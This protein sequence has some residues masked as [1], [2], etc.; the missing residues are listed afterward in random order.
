MSAFASTSRSATHS[1]G[2]GNKPKLRTDAATLR[3]Y[4]CF[5]PNGDVL[6]FCN[7]NP[8]IKAIRRVTR[9]ETSPNLGR[10]FWSC[11]N[12]IEGDGCGLFLWC[13][14]A[15]SKGRDF[16][17]PPPPGKPA[18]GAP[19]NP[20]TP[21]SSPQKR[22]R[23][24]SPSVFSPAGSAV[25]STPSKP[26]V[27]ES[28]DD[29]DFDSFD[30][31]LDDEIEDADFPSSSTLSASPGKKP[32]FDSFSSSGAS[33]PTP[34][35]PST[36]QLSQG[37]HWQAA[38]GAGAGGGTTRARTGGF[39]AIRLDPDSPFHALQ[40]SLFG[41]SG[42]EGASGSSPAPPSPSK[43]GPSAQSEELSALDSLFA[44]LKGL[45]DL[46]DAAKKEREKDARLQTAAKRKEE[47][48]R[49]AVERAK[50][51]TEA[52]RRENE[53]LKERIRMLEEENNELRTR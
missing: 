25:P 32:R 44:G 39:D 48:L 30:A 45:S 3:K 11:G 1:K 47:T 15:A 23:A 14:E 5:L 22:P 19:V 41:G 16:T 24:C 13:D 20:P 9:K 26:L 38:G 34:A 31:T 6:C 2:G 27:T 53:G 29:V 10:E 37:P 12:W 35:T 51:E 18:L 42:G 49:K 8:R 17:T 50:E 40:K 33:R 52:L 46:A 36:S 21:S 43:A 28:F 4:G 7:T